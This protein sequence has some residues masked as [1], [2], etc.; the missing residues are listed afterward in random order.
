MPARLHFI[1]PKFTTLTWKE[2]ET[3]L[4]LIPLD[5]TV[6]GQEFIRQGKKEDVMEALN[7]R[8]GIVPKQIA[9][10]IE[11]QDDLS[12]LKTLFKQAILADFLTTFKQALPA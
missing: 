9:E 7:L 6:V 1:L 8:F 2:I 10:V 3:M 5:Q 4:K 12:T 11:Q